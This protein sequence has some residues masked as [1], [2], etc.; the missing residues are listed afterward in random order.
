MVKVW[1]PL[2]KQFSFGNRAAVGGKVLSHLFFF[3]GSIG[4]VRFEK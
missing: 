2:R 3:R 4:A 1:K